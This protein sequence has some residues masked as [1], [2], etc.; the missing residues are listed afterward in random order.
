MGE[1]I[2]MER[3]VIGDWVIKERRPSG[4]GS[5]RLVLL[6]HG[7]TGDEHSMDVFAQKLPK[8][9]W[10]VA[11]RGIYPSPTK[12]FSWFIEQGKTFP[13]VDDFTP[14][15][16]ALFELLVPDHFPGADLERVDLL[17]FSQGAALAYAIAFLHSR[18]VGKLA[19]IA[20]FLPHGCEALARNRP[21]SGK[22]VFV[23]HG[24]LDELVPIEKGRECVVTLKEAGGEV[25]YCEDEVGHKLSKGCFGRL[26]KFFQEV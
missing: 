5:S 26:R 7:W 6:L 16:E 18:W 11:L 15:I 17:G 14:A 24:S 2:K 25:T 13:W 12:G 19:G 1:W 10:L 8:H 3:R 21:L 9:D 4:K 20:G 22:R 23:A